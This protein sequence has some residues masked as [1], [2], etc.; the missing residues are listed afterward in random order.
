MLFIGTYIFRAIHDVKSN[1]SKTARINFHSA[2]LFPALSR[3][4]HS[5][6]LRII[7][8]LFFSF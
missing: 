8:R 5:Y 6:N 3:L 2:A 1:P 7:H 4:A